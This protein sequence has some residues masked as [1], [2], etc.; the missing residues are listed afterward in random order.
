MP[1]TLASRARA[2]S[3]AK[4]GDLLVRDPERAKRLALHW[5]EW[6]IDFSKERV[7]AA[8][9]EALV[10]HADA[11]G[12]PRWIDALF[13]GERVNLSESRP[14]LHTALR[15]LDDTPVRVDGQDVMPSIREAR[16]RIRAIADAIREGRR[17]GATG[18]PITDVVSIGIGGSDL[19]PRMVC[20]ALAGTDA[21]PVRVSF[22]SNVDPEAIARALAPLD[23]A[24]TAFVVISKTFTTQETLANAT[25]A[26]DW[27]ARS[28]PGAGARCALRRRLCERGASRRIRHRR[29]RR[30]A[31]V[32]LGR[33]PLFAVVGGG[34]ADRDPL[35][36]RCVRCTARGC[37][38]DGRARAHR[39]A[40]AER[41]RRCSRWSAGGT[42]AGSATR[43]GS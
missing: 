41:R 30:A 35:R 9:L 12:V 2:L 22:V 10:A 5:G 18:K 36:S 24:S 1:D 32:G 27:L 40:R 38:R 19:G 26:R 21:P 8:A 17:R 20:D 37:R 39:T 7:D 3:G 14:A 25:A 6:R 15:Q 33:R 43:S 29:R 34:P 16:R 4:L 42:R 31:D 23:P 28:L 13:A 11:I